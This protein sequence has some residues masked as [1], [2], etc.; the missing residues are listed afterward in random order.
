MHYHIH[1]KLQDAAYFKRSKR[2]DKGQH[3]TRPR[4]W[5]VEYL[6][7]ITKWHRQF[8]QTYLVH[9]AAWPWA[10]LKVQKGYAK[11]N[12][13]FVWDFY[14][15]NIHVMLQHDTGNLRRVIAFTRFRTP[16]TAHPGNDNTLQSK[17]LRGKKNPRQS[18]FFH[19]WQKTYFL[20]QNDG[21]E[22]KIICP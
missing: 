2:S 3:Q 15:E 5:C 22:K 18:F 4:F 12:V 10:S 16:P 9:K 7:E 17:G 14:V 13:E 20:R 1:K 19:F 11:V 21:M 6:C 8:Q